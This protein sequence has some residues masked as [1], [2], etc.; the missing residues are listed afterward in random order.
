MGRII[1]LVYNLNIQIPQLTDTELNDYGL[2]WQQVLAHPDVGLLKPEAV[3]GRDVLIVEAPLY[4]RASSA[5]A[6]VAYLYWSKFN[7]DFARE[8]RTIFTGEIEEEIEEKIK[9]F[10]HRA[11]PIIALFITPTYFPDLVGAEYGVNL[12]PMQQT[13]TFVAA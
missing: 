7:S 6:V 12:W 9:A 13:G 1:T 2:A 4:R 5:Y 10:Q 3:G 11:R 8:S